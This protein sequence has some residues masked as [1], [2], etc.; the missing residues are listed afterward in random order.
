MK[1]ETIAEIIKVDHVDIAAIRERIISSR[2][3][4]A[5]RYKLA[6]RDVYNRISKKEEKFKVYNCYKKAFWNGKRYQ[7]KRYFFYSSDKA[8]KCAK[9]IAR[10]NHYTIKVFDENDGLVAKVCGQNNR[11]PTCSTTNR[12]WCVYV[13]PDS[14]LHDTHGYLKNKNNE[15]ITFRSM[16]T[17]KRHA[18]FQRIDSFEIIQFTGSG[19]R[20][21]HV[22]A[23]RYAREGIEEPKGFFAK[24]F[25]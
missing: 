17:A 2:V 4:K 6:V 19:T 23:F 11:Y 8:I 12:F 16:N 15:I 13:R 20:I 25:E 3:E 1:I 9:S 22:K 18:I 21:T 7:K 14:V 10:N 24:I 5:E